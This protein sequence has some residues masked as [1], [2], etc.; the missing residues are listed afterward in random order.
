MKL[1]SLKRNSRL[2]KEKVLEL[3]SAGFNNQEIQ[4]EFGVKSNNEP[5]IKYFQDISKEIQEETMQSEIVGP[6]D[7]MLYDSMQEMGDQKSMKE[8]LVGKNFDGDAILKR[9]WGKTLYDMTYRLSTEKGFAR[10]FYRRRTRR[11]YLV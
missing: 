4:E 10:G 2:E 7:Q 9:G 6:D 8:I 5:F 3:K 1:V 11:L